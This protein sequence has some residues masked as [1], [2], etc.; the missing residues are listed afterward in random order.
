MDISNTWSALADGDVWRSVN[1]K[2]KRKNIMRKWAS[3]FSAMMLLWCVSGCA[4]HESREENNTAVSQTRME[5]SVHLTEFLKNEITDNMS[6]A[7]IVD[8]FERMCSIP[9]EDDMILFET[10]TFSFTEEPVFLISFVRQF[11]NEEEDEFLQIHV[12]VLYQPTSENSAFNESTWDDELSE[13]I[14]DYIR[15]SQVFSYAKDKEYIK[16]DIHLDET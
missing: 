11:P 2:I 4:Q 8:V 6:F 1:W 9:V 3:L 12:D 5:E 15:N 10:G 14:F 16:I 7:Q 13:N